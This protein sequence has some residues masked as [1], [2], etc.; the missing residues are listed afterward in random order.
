MSGYTNV[1]ERALDNYKNGLFLKLEGSAGRYFVSTFLD[2]GIIKTLDEKGN[3]VID[4]YG[5]N[6]TLK[7][8][9][10]DYD[11]IDELWIEDENFMEELEEVA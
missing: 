7:K 4:G 9:V 11:R 6:I 5:R 10:I 3:D 1:Y 2:S 8:A